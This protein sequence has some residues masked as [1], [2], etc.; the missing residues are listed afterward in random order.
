MIG[1]MV[2]SSGDPGYVYGKSVVA[3]T[4]DGNTKTVNRNYL[5]IW[6]KEDGNSWK[7]VL[8]LVNIAR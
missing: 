8:D 5:R 6:K 3:I 2:A 1:A 7:I 4:K